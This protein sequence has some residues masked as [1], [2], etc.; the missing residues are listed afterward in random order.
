MIEF[1][2]S[3]GYTLVGNLNKPKNAGAIVIFAHGLHSGKHSSRNNAI[4]E[5]LNKKG[6]AVFLI[7]FTGHGDSDGTMYEVTVEQMAD[8]LKCAI[9]HIAKDFKRIGISGSSLGGTVALLEASTDNRIT[10][11][12]L[13]AP[14]SKG[15]YR[16][17]K[18]IKIP[19]MILQGSEDIGILAEARTLIE[20]LAGEKKLDLIKGASHLF[21]GYTDEMVKR[22]V[23]WFTAYL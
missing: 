8:D 17:A 20:S 6:I 2:N 13:R 23:D 1:K 11:M 10:A 4:A 9:D 22:T 5:A 12:V 18:K 15:Y 16:Y 14:P 19:V 3:L 21:E 7:D